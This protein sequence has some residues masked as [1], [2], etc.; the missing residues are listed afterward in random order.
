MMTVCS[1]VFSVVKLRWL[2][3]TDIQYDG[4]YDTV[5][6]WWSDW[7]I[8]TDDD[9]DC[10]CVMT[11]EGIVHSQ[12]VLPGILMETLLF[13]DSCSCS[14]IHCWP[15]IHS[16]MLGIVC[17][18]L[19]HWSVLLSMI[20]LMR[21]FCWCLRDTLFVMEGIAMFTGDVIA[22]RWC[23]PVHLI[24][25]SIYS[26]G[27]FSIVRCSWW[28]L[29][30]IRWPMVSWQY[31]YIVISDM[32]LYWC[33]LEVTERGMLTAWNRATMTP[34]AIQWREISIL[35]ITVL[36]FIS[37]MTLSH[38]V[39]N[40]TLMIHCWWKVMCLSDGYSFWCWYRAVMARRTCW[41]L[42]RSDTV[43]Q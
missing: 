5:I 8:H 14:F 17:I 33:C 4:E 42:T 23:I 3:S 29:T 43:I 19:M 35:L 20:P 28:F 15:A 2:Y 31:L 24:P 27:V 26:S 32:W 12:T 18:H 36:T 7:K 40:L 39:I 25:C 22:M 13:I 16:L 37:F 41:K 1:L 10:V 6:F 34:V 38:S 9:D 11:H 21:C 30:D